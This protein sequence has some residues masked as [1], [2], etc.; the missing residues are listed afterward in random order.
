MDFKKLSI[1][2]KLQFITS[3]TATFEFHPSWSTNVSLFHRP[4]WQSIVTPF[5]E[6]ESNICPD[7][8]DDGGCENC[9]SCFYLELHTSQTGKTF[10]Q[11]Q[12]SLIKHSEY[13]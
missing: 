12:V 3:T 7:N 2:I 13:K 9:N 1:L 5:S 10:F 4:S 6:I 11:G 8:F